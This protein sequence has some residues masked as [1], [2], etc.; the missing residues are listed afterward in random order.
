M[1]STYPILLYKVVRSF[2]CNEGSRRLLNRYGSSY[3]S[4][5]GFQLFWRLL[6]AYFNSKMNNFQY[7]RCIDPCTVD[8][9]GPQA[10]CQVVNHRA[11]CTCPAG[12]IPNPTPVVGCVRQPV[13][14]ASNAEC[15][16]QQVCDGKFC[17]NVCFNDKTCAVNEVCDNNVCQALCR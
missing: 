7:C 1:P 3:R 8:S 15:P 9:C 5:V 10:N 2:L 12:F 6:G 11:Q 13:T 16:D 14:C 17:K 4:R